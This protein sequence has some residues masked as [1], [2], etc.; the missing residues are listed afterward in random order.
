MRSPRKLSRRHLAEVLGEKTLH[1]HDAKA[2]TQS[3]AAFLLESGHTGDLGSL[4]RD[5]QA[6]RAEHGIVEATVVSAF[7]INKQVETDVR[8]VLHELYP[9]A[10]TMIINERVNPEIVG[11]LRLELAHDQ[12]DLTVQGKLNTFKRLTALRK[13]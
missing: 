11:G 8:S 4:M 2:L 1:I 10:K 12:L 6:Y 7:P 3:I 13:D 5:I 9:H